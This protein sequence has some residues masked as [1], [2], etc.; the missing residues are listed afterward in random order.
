LNLN[1]KSKAKY[2]WFEFIEI[3][4]AMKLYT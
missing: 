3:K 2:N 4:K 1:E